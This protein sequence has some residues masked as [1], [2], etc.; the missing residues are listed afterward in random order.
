MAR[1]HLNF[2]DALDDAAHWLERWRLIP[3]RLSRWI[4]D[5]FECSLISQRCADIDAHYAAFAA[6]RDAEDEAFDAAMRR[7]IR[8]HQ[9]ETQ[10]AS[11]TE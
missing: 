4:C 8:D 5:R 3:R 6:S 2:L 1:Q 7:R 11:G 10:N 9:E